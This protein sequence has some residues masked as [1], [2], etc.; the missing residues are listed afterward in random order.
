MFIDCLARNRFLGSVTNNLNKLKVEFITSKHFLSEYVAKNRK[1]LKKLYKKFKDAENI[2]ARE[3]V[4]ITGCYVYAKNM[5][6]DSIKSGIIVRDK[7]ND[8]LNFNGYYTPFWYVKTTT[9]FTTAP[10]QKHCKSFLKA[11][12]KFFK[13]QSTTQPI[14]QYR[15][16]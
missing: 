9:D 13:L 6:G 14:C 16:K 7:V 2:K 5:S 1:N 4:T 3:Y 11:L 15:S 10:E 8:Y 12:K